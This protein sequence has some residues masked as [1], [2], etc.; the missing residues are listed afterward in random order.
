MHGRAFS[1]R[2]LGF[3]LALLVST[4]TFAY[5]LTGIVSAGDDLRAARGA[6]SKERQ[7]PVSDERCRE[8]RDDRVRL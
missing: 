7:T 4:A 1:L 5:S 8:H 6:Q 2:R 3:A